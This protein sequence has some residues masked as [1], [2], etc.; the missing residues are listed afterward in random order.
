MAYFERLGPD[1]FRATEH[2]GGAWNT[3][4]QHIAPALGLIAH[5]IEIEHRRRR[6][7]PLRIARLSYDILGTLPIGEA[8]IAV[9]LLRPGRTIELVEACLAH[10]GRAAVIARC[11]LLQDFDTSAFV[12]TALPA[13]PHR[14]DMAI[15]DVGS[16][17]PGGFVK[18]VE[19]RRIDLGAGRA[20]S[21]VRPL[22][23]ILD[24]EAVS[25]TARA[26]GLIDIANGLAPRVPPTEV[27]FPNVDLT[28]HLFEEPQGEWLGF[29]TAVS[30]GGAGIGLTHSMLHDMRG[31]IGTVAQ[32]LTIRPF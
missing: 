19:V 22:V 17:W 2:V 5:A 6:H 16:T 27:A 13:I 24:G 12:G 10:R 30:F 1:R 15:G 25:P 28:V 4:E 7:D 21:W 26:L 18:S 9:S 32:S 8:E 20:T 31:P 14:E 29:D 3:A 23:P 11:W